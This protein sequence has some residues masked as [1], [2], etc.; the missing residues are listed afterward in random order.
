[1]CVIKITDSDGEFCNILLPNLLPF[2]AIDFI[3]QEFDMSPL[4]FRV[5]TI[6]LIKYN[7][8]KIILTKNGWTAKTSLD[9]SVNGAT[10]I[11]IVD[12]YGNAGLPRKSGK[13]WIAQPWV[14]RFKAGEIVWE[15]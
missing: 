3:G 10:G 9:L 6:G 5:N 15:A 7:S 4:Y 1:M 11:R 13:G 14:I 12:Y 8:G 2:V